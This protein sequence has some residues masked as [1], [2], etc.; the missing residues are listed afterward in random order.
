VVVV[1][2]TTI[3]AFLWSILLMMLRQDLPKKLLRGYTVEKDTVGY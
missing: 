2:G 1:P 3:L